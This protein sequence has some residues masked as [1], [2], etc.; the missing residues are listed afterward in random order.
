[1]GTTDNINIMEFSDAYLMLRNLKNSDLY[2]EGFESR[3]EIPNEYL[4]QFEKLANAVKETAKTKSKSF[5]L[6]YNNKLYRVTVIYGVY[7]ITAHL[8][9]QPMRMIPLAEINIPLTIKQY[10]TS[11]RLNKGGLIFVVGAPGEGKTTTCAAILTSRLKMY[12]GF[13]LAIEDPPEL[14]LDGVHGL[15]RCIQ[16]EIKG[17]NDYDE[18]GRM[19]MRCFPTDKPGI[20]FIS[21]IRDG[22]GASLALRAALDG[23][24]VLATLHADSIISALKRII[25]LA[26]T[27][28]DETAAR[29]LLYNGF[30]LCLHQ[31]RSKNQIKSEI[32]LDT[33]SAV[34]HLQSGKFD[35]LGTEIDFQKRAIELNKPIQTRGI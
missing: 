29:Q 34:P 8:R 35:L 26:S 7:G 25:S 30:R 18:A 10:T 15:G 3:F 4:E 24:L 13:C 23:R 12:G 19:S 6:K 5:R 14:P 21:E 20:V 2:F 11:R 16:Y 22:E 1:M 9:S 27:V 31:S 32:L 33:I 28:M 17:K